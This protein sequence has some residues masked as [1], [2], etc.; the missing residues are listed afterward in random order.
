MS[1]IGVAKTFRWK[2]AHV[3]RRSITQEFR[4][5]G[6]CWQIRLKKNESFKNLAI[7]PIF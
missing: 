5:A 6:S 3:I 1:I 4:E 7:N 2:D